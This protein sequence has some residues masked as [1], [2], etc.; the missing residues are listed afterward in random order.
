MRI[1]FTADAD[2]LNMLRMRTYSDGM[3]DPCKWLFAVPV[4]L[5]LELT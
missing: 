3:S 1:P 4:C 5:A 2:T